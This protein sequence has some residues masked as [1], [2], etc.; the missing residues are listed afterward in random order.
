MKVE[1]RLISA[2]HQDLHDLIE[3]NQFR[4][5]LYY[6]LQGISVSLPPLRDR[7][8]KKALIRQMLA[9]EAGDGTAADIDEQAL[10][11]IEHYAWPGNIRQLRNALRTALALRDGPVITARDLPEELT[12]TGIG[13]PM[14]AAGE[15][16]ETGILP[17]S[18]ESAE[19]NALIEGL[20][21]HRWKITNLAREL[22]VSRNTLYRKMRRLDIQDPGK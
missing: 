21:R 22:S 11:L 6:R 5:D 10:Q 4:E 20:E 13:E 17:N 3:K 15:A 7:T 14:R 2:T 16:A 9:A 12:C 18:L 19:K 8:D 1:F